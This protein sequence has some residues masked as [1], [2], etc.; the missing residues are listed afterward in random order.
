MTTRAERA[1]KPL[2]DR[3]E[4]LETINKDLLATCKQVHNLIAYPVMGIDLFH[5]VREILEQAIAKAEGK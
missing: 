1:F 4:Q 5:R 3:I 2:H